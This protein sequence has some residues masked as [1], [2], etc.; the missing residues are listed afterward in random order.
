MSNYYY[1]TLVGFWSIWYND[2]TT[3]EYIT[4]T[5][6]GQPRWISYIWGWLII[7]INSSKSIIVK[8]RWNTEWSYGNSIDHIGKP[9]TVEM[10]TTY[11]SWKAGQTVILRSYVTHTDDAID[12]VFWIFEHEHDFK[13]IYPSANPDKYRG[14]TQSYPSLIISNLTY[15]DEGKYKC[16][17]TNAFGTGISKTALFLNV[18][19]ILLS[20]HYTNL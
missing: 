4:F 17:A 1:K 14:S 19:G 13:T 2:L 15:A 5:L 8:Y 11:F 12:S 7:V 6:V 16:A 10:N 20:K 3:Q 18:T 9:P